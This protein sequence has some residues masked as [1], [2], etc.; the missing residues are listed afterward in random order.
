M[1][2][3]QISKVLV[4]T[5]DEQDLP[6]L[7]TGELGYSTDVKKLYIGDDPTNNPENLI[8]NN[9][10][11]LTEHSTIAF[12]QIDLTDG[13][14]FTTENLHISGGQNGYVLET[15]GQGNV[16]WGSKGSL[17]YN[18]TNVTQSSP[19]VLTFSSNHIFTNSQLI[20]IS[21]IYGIANVSAGSLTGTIT[22]NT[23]SPIVTGSGTSFTTETAIG[24]TIVY[25]SNTS[26][27][28]GTVLSIA[29]NTSLTLR[30]SS[31]ANVVG[32]TV[33][34]GPSGLN[35]TTAFV[36]VL[37]S[38]QV[39]LYGDSALTTPVSTSSYSAYYSGGRVVGL[40]NSGSGTSVGGTN[41][42]VQFNNNGTFAGNA[43]FTFNYATATLTVTGTS[44]V[45]GNLN[46]TLNSNLGNLATANYYAGTLTTNAQPNIT[47]LGT[48]T[49][50][51][52]SGDANV[53]NLSSA[54][55]VSATGNVAANNFT[56]ANVTIVGSLG[57]VSATSNV[58]AGNLRTGG[59]VTATGNI[60]GGNILSGGIVSAS[61][62]VIGGNFV[63]GGLVT[64]TGNGTFGNI[65]T[66]R[67][68]AS[69][70]SN[71]G[72]LGT[73]GLISATGNITGS[74]LNTSG[75]VVSTVASGTAPFVVT[76]TTQVANLNVATA[77]TA[78]TV[79]TNAQPNITS[80]GILSS[81]SVSG[82]VTAG[83]VI[84]TLHVGNLSGTGNS[85]VGNL[86]AT[87]I[88]STTLSASGNANVG[89][90]GA[91]NIVGTLTTA[92]QTNITAV[93]TLGSLNVTGN[94]TAGNVSVVS[95]TVGGTST[96]L[97]GTTLTT[98][99]NTTAG[100]V[101]GNWTL[102]SGSRLNATYADLAEYYAADQMYEPGTVLMFGGANEVTIADVATTKVAG[103]VSTN[104]AYV[105]NGDC[106]GNAVAIALQGR[107]P[108]KVIGNVTKGDMMVSGGNGYAMASA[109]PTMG[110][111]IGKS[112]ENFTGTEGTIEIAVGRL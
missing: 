29:N 74:N 87:G 32:E 106:Q 28:I 62:N 31:F 30:A 108:T 109:Q 83:N 53:G 84:A 51:S 13:A 91:T 9:T 44:N 80:V 6:Q 93:G 12:N 112:L 100:T 7:D 33:K 66:G 17:T 65:S 35:G 22:A 50:V 18:I 110:T 4:R 64:A 57:T 5:G 10:E 46:V 43:N 54:G 1:A 75:Q 111:V 68:T 56:S 16:S 26:S 73:G 107:V 97:Y 95:G 19:S 85:N 94:V 60:T 61:S 11:V 14:Y 90:I 67:F 59:V 81:L 99:A 27:V 102:S 79:T 101:T 70:N 39:E 41:T 15:D 25:S 92:S 52:V 76:S 96:I 40:L 88:F 77:G 105:M 42:H 45:A 2:I 104:P 78:G 3:I 63:T 34:S 86:G 69:G 71:V 82:N 36:K 37:S 24:Q 47:S 98:G 48:L 23:L 8:I 58:S 38:N 21:D 49:S 89:N 103:V 72:N 20:T 55:F